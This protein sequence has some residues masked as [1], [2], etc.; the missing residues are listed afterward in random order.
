M[1]G[2]NKQEWFTKLGQL[3]VVGFRGMTVSDEVKKLIHD[4]RVGNFILFGRNIGT[5]VDVLDLT[6]ALQEEAKRAGHDKPLL[7][8]TDQENGLVQRLKY[9]ATAF[10]GAMGIGA[11]NNLDIAYQIGEATGR[12]LKEVGINWNLAPVVDVNNNPENPVINVRS[13]GESPRR[14][15][16]LALAWMKGCQE[17]GVA[18]TLKHFPGHGDTNVDSHLDLPVIHHSL[19]RLFDVELLPFLEG[20]KNGATTI[21]TAHIYFSAR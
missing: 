11:T 9:P 5:G 16:D 10:P 7:I 8:C 15:K 14:V 4:Y 13:F 3:L 21:M 1:I 12:E 2:L 17:A 6:S 19:K 20:I 18:T